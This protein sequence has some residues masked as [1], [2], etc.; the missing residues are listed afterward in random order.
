M[1][2]PTSNGKLWDIIS[3]GTEKRSQRRIEDPRK[4]PWKSKRCSNIWGVLGRGELERSHTRERRGGV[5]PDNKKF[6]KLSLQLE[7]RKTI[8]ND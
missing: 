6:N 8:K 3:P 7:G 5:G 2:V 1:R 4:V